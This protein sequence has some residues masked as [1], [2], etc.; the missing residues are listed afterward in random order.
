MKYLLPICFLLLT[1][2]TT[3]QNHATCDG[4]RYIDDVF[5]NVDVTAGLKYGEGTTINNNFQELYLDVY[6]PAG[7]DA[8][9]RPAIILAFGGSFIGGERTDLDWL[10]EAYAKKGFVAVTID[11]RLYDLPLF[12]LPTEEEMQNVV[13]KAVGDMKAAIRF[14]R[15]DARYKQ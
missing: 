1:I 8:E 14:L 4:M 15:E 3:A 5:A 7:D 12:P 2:S 10:C 13:T 9:M 11:Y 6:E